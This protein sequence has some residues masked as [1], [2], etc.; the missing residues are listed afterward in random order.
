MSKIKVGTLVYINDVKPESEP[1]IG[2]IVAREVTES[3][4]VSEK[5]GHNLCEV[6]YMVKPVGVTGFDSYKILNKTQIVPIKDVVSGPR[7]L[8]KVYNMPNGYILT[9]VAV[10][11]KFK[12][13]NYE[14]MREHTGNWFQMGWSMC[15]PKDSYDAVLGNKIARRRAINHPF[16][17]MESLF[18]A[19]FN[20]DTMI[21]LMDVKAKYVETHMD[22]FATPGAGY[23]V[24]D[25]TDA[26]TVEE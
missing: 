8:V 4:E 20:E 1:V 18:S 16:C 5:N 22:S 11:D 19:E 24:S 26:E 12:Y 7:E 17:K 14:T 6:K 23:R 3:D 15:S 13:C 2:Q 10:A 9:L 21:A 25:D